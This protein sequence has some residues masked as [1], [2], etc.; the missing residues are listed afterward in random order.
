MM[1][2]MCLS[3]T[4]RL[5]PLGLAV[6]GA[7]GAGVG[8]VLTR[9][10]R[11]GLRVAET[12]VATVIAF[13]LLPGVARWGAPAFD[14]EGLVTVCIGAPLGCAAAWGTRRGEAGGGPYPEI[15]V[16]IAM[17]AA[18]VGLAV[19]VIG[20]LHDHLPAWQRIEIAFA[21]SGGAA[22]LSLGALVPGARWFHAVGGAAIVFHGPRLLQIGVLHQLPLGMVSRWAFVLGVS[23]A[24]ACLVGRHLR[25][26]VVARAAA[27]TGLPVARVHDGGAGAA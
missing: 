2:V 6:V 25:A 10:V 19:V 3:S 23:A 11:P 7:I 16:G 8:E 13:V 21:V 15:G 5:P 20:V 18:A 26:L 17:M 27:T 14:Q 4:L 24:L 9:A 22:G 12:V 1:L